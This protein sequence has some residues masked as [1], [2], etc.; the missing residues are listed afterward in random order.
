MQNQPFFVTAA[1]GFEPLLAA[2]LIELGASEVKE[3][4]AG[5]SFVGELSIAY[6]VCLWSRLASRVLLPLAIFPAL[7]TDQLYAEVQK[8]D[9]AEHLSVAR[10]FAV[11]CTTVRSQIN[12]TRYGALRVKDAIVDQFRARSGERPSISVEQPDLRINLHLFK[13]QATLSIDL[14]GDSLHRRGYRID[15]VHA[16][17]KENLAAAILIRG[18]WPEIAATGGALVDPMCGSGTLPLEAGLMATDTAPGLLRDYFGF[19]GW[20]QFDDALWQ[21]LREEALLRQHDGLKRRLAPIVGY[22]SD[23]RAIKAA[24]QHAQNAGLEKII[25]FEKRTLREFSAPVGFAPGLLVANPPYGERL[26]EEHELPPLYNLLGEQ[27]ANKCVGWKAAVITSN[28]QLGRS[29][30]LRAGKINTLY[31]GALKCQL[32]QFVLDEKNRWQSL[33]AGAGRAV[34]KELSPG[35]E[36]FANRLRKNLKKFEK[37]ANRERID[38]YRLYDADLPE[39]AVAVDLYGDEVHL[40][41]YRAP[42]DIDPKKAAQRLQDVQDALPQVLD[43]SSD[44]IHLKIRQQQK[45][46]QQYEKQARRGILKE[47]QEGNCKFLVNLTDYLDTGLFLDHRPARQLIQNM[48]HGS[49]FLNLFA[50]TGSATVHAL[51]GGAMETTTVDMSRT[52]LE[53][54]RKNIALNDFDPDDEELIQTDCLVWIDGVQSERAAAF[55][56]IFL[57]PPTF[58]NSKSMDSSFDVQRDHV[59]LLRKVAKLLSPGGTLIF[60]NNLRNFK[61]DA[62]ALP[63]LQIESLTDKTIPLDFARHPRIHNCW[64]IRH[65][66]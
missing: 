27:M 22:D 54:A 39:Y 15:G 24:W 43:I 31:N 3:E 51:V 58:S 65:H 64:L 48:A 1:L 60:S 35:A 28:P 46:K 42:K 4:R 53:W 26:G 44:K 8:I 23:S 57:D 5:V 16:P 7:D 30:G 12:H 25:H 11:D 33:A 21:R 61:L 63:E 20:Q 14:S 38:C 36:M 17:L 41:E 47:V 19:F 66:S 45:G 50:Y 29:I 59:G 13:D 9:W 55:D 40:Q 37:W 32:L 49:R 56:L 62:D 6:K 18:G 52:Y 2:E 10:T 34:K